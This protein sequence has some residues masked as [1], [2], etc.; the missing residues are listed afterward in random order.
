MGLCNKYSIDFRETLQDYG[1]L[2]GDEQVRLGV[3]PS[4]TGGG[5][6]FWLFVTTY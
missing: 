4:Q 2:L 6:P 5:Q 3:D 1:L